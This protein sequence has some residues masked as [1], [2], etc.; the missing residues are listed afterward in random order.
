MNVLLP[1]V[2]AGPHQSGGVSVYSPGNKEQLSTALHDSQQ[3]FKLCK[4]VC[5]YVCMCVCMCVSVCVCVC[6][7]VF[8]PVKCLLMSWLNMNRGGRALSC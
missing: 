5:M 1:A 3:C 8:P 7:F 4:L 6:F 2:H